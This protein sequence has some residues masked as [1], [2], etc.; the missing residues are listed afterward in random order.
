MSKAQI[1]RFLKDFSNLHGP[2]QQAFIHAIADDVKARK[3]IYLPLV[4]KQCS[5]QIELLC[6]LWVARETK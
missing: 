6:S 5:P 2:L 3:G 4:F 1:T